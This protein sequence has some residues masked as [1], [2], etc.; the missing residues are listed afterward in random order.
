MN[1]CC[2]EAVQ[3][4]NSPDSVQNGKQSVIHHSVGTTTYFVV[5]ERTYMTVYNSGFKTSR[6]TT[7]SK[8]SFVFAMPTFPCL[9]SKINKEFV[10]TPLFESVSR[11]VRCKF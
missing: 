6:H 9:N 1:G 5:L 10:S 3:N 8:A 4:G 7:H 11:H 2:T